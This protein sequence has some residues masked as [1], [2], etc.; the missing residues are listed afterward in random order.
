MP[1]FEYHQEVDAEI[2]REFAILC[3]LD[4]RR[5]CPQECSLNNLMRA[6]FLGRT[7]EQGRSYSSLVES[8]RDPGNEKLLDK[9]REE[10]SEVLQRRGLIESCKYYP[11]SDITQQ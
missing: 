6:L 11:E 8:F 2:E 4:P 5:D 7:R 9:F 10:Q 1:E 3:G